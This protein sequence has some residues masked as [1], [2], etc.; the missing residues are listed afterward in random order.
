MFNFLR[1]RRNV[2]YSLFCIEHE[3]PCRMPSVYFV[4][5]KD[6]K[7]VIR[8]QPHDKCGWDI[9]ELCYH[10]FPPMLKW[11][12][13]YMKPPP[14]APSKPPTGDENLGVVSQPSLRFTKLLDGLSQ[15]VYALGSGSRT[16][17]GP[18]LLETMLQT[19]EELRARYEH[20]AEADD[21][22]QWAVHVL[23]GEA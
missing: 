17:T 13:R 3:P 10:T 19:I 21:P 16:R 11:T 7:R 2:K 18:L 12:R 5:D 23:D 14:A 22:E 9:D 4:W 20:L 6:D 15:G 1:R 8:D